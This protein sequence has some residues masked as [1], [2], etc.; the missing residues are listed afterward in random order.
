MAVELLGGVPIQPLDDD[1]ATVPGGLLYF[2]AHDTTTPQDTYV[3]AAGT[4]PASHPV[5]LDGAGRA[6]VYVTTGL[7]YDIFFTDP[8]DNVL[9]TTADSVP[10]PFPP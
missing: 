7:A 9:W 10:D 5:V 6:T 4:T 8:D 1:G 3:D 2:Y